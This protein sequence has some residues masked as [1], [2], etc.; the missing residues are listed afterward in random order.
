MCVKSLELWKDA[1]KKSKM[2]VYHQTGGLDYGDKN[3]KTLI[4]TLGKE[5]ISF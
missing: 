5:L 1:E 2:K 3:N 4:E